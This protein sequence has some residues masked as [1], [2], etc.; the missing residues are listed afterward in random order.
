MH[1]IAQKMDT[2]ILLIGHTHVPKVFIMDKKTNSIK[3][4]DIIGHDIPI[5]IDNNKKYI[6]NIGSVGQPRDRNP[7]SCYAIYDRLECTISYKRMPYNTNITIEKIIEN[8]LPRFL[9]ETL[10]R[11]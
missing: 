7:D 6:F 10:S 1:G 4:L 5:S 9:Y 2:D 3:T 11:R 8:R